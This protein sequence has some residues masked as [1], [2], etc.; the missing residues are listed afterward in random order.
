MPAWRVTPREI[1]LIEFYVGEVAELG[2]AFVV[3]GE[4]ADHGGGVKA[5]NVSGTDEGEAEADGLT[6]LLDGPA[7][8]LYVYDDFRRGIDVGCVRVGTGDSDP[9][10]APQP[11]V[12]S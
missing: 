4:R 1:E 8:H 2:V 12:E 9:K 10:P 5:D 7:K 11:W 6:I 3:A